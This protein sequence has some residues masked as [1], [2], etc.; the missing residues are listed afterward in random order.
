[1]PL[2]GEVQEHS[3]EL[4]GGDAHLDTQLHANRSKAITESTYGIQ[5]KSGM[6]AVEVKTRF[7]RAQN[8]SKSDLTGLE[9]TR[10]K[11]LCRKD[12]SAKRM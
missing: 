1:M 9:C 11:L 5:L 2:R 4:K 8:P 12:T 7:T 3:N 10:R 6:K